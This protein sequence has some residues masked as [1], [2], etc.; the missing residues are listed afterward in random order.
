MEDHT[1]FHIF[2]VRMVSRV[3]QGLVVIRV[4]METEVCVVHLVDLDLQGP[5]VHLELRD[6]L[7]LLGRMVSRLGINMF[8]FSIYIVIT[9]NISIV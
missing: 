7:E 2:K 1:V 6:H 9:A 5:R 8:C 3:E 4:L